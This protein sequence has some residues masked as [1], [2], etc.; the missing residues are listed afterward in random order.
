MER[1]YQEG[2]S[3]TAVFTFFSIYFYL[4][5]VFIKGWLLE[6]GCFKQF[7][8][9]KQYKKSIKQAVKSDKIDA[10]LVDNHYLLSFQTVT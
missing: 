10:M 3:S 8:G 1:G 2:N 4:I 7:Y 9:L 6:G 5:S